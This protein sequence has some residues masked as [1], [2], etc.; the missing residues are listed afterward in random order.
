LDWSAWPTVPKRDHGL[1][2][3]V[4]VD[5]KAL[6][7]EGVANRGIAE[8]YDSQS[9]DRP[10][11]ILATNLPDGGDESRLWITTLADHGIR[12]VYTEPPP[13]LLNGKVERSHRTDQQKFYQLLN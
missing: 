7:K 3:I 13:P 6:T 10:L 5:P 9:V 2:S 1:E 12:H 11:E 8:S 4:S